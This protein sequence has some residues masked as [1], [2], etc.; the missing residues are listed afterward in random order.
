MYS[1]SV[2]PVDTPP[3]NWKRAG[4][5]ASALAAGGPV[6]SR[7]YAEE[8]VAELRD[9]STVAERH[10]R[11]LTG[12]G[13]ALPLRTGEVVDRPGWARTAAGGLGAMTSG[14][15]PQGTLPKPVAS[16]LATTSGAQLGVV[17]ALLAGRVLGQYDP[18]SGAGGNGTLLLVAP[19]VVAAEL[20]MDVPRSD[21]RLWVCLHEGT[22]RLQFTAVPWLRDYFSGQVRELL[23]AVGEQS[24][25]GPTEMVSAL[26]GRLRAG[27]WPRSAID[28][29]GLMQKPEQ[30]ATL[31]RLLALS[32]LLEGHADHV[33]DAVGPEVVP[34]VA[35]IRKRFTERRRGGSV[36][37]RVLRTL[38]GL[39]EKLRQYAEGSAFTRAVVESVGMA[40]FNAV[41]NSPDTLPDRAELADPARWLR[42]VH[43]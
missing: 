11:E 3:L 31:E 29:V 33:M 23:S 15:L 7:G 5:V 13:E 32:T 38:L 17:L 42:R 9:G 37:D 14:A 39:D 26:V 30:R 16:A 19:N 4:D 36:A 12:L 1:G 28:V 20:A 6:V 21:F 27:Q 43:T 24:A 8:A 40:G 2:A 35:R 22:H 25:T 34:S 10:V 41:W 18:F